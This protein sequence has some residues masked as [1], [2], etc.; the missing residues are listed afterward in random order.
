[1]LMVTS[2]SDLAPLAQTRAILSKFPQVA[3]LHGVQFGYH[4]LPHL[5]ANCRR[6]A[7]PNRESYESKK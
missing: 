5:V 3:D 1:M 2:G 4:L 7:G 6:Y